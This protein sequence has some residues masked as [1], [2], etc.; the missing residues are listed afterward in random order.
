MNDEHDWEMWS[1]RAMYPTWN[2]SQCG[3]SWSDSK[4]FPKKG[5]K[6]A[7]CIPTRKVK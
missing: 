2:C 4:P 7:I 6:D 1:E 3:A 5:R